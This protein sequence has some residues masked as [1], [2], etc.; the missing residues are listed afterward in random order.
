[1]GR[2]AEVAGPACLGPQAWGSSSGAMGPLV[3]FSCIK[4]CDLYCWIRVV[5]ALQRARDRV[6]SV[7]SPLHPPG[8]GSPPAPMCPRG[9]FCEPSTDPVL[10]L[11]A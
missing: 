11:E 9:P 10:R 3:N 1:M 4:F 8:R 6:G 2:R 5:F 7:T